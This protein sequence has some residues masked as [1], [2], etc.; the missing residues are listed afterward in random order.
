MGDKKPPKVKKSKDKSKG[1]KGGAAPPPE[2][3]D[4]R[5]VKK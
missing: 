2:Q 4:D 5:K 3:P 1:V